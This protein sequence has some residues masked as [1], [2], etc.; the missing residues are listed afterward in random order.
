[1]GAG[2]VVAVGATVLVAFVAI[3]GF[4]AVLMREASSLGPRLPDYRSNIE[5]KNR[6][7][8]EAKIRM[9]P[10]VAEPALAPEENGG[11][12]GASA[13]PSEW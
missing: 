12:V 3:F 6:S 8:I 5:A 1:M 11:G 13:S 4:A 7:N 2:R 9:L 10:Q